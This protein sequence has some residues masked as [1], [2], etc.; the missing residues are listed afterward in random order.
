MCFSMDKKRKHDVPCE[1]DFTRMIELNLM[2]VVSGTECTG[3]VPTPPI[4]IDSADS[5]NEIYDVPVEESTVNTPSHEDD[6]K[7]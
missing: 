5:Y 6:K 1:D 2:N 4:D 3:L 7:K